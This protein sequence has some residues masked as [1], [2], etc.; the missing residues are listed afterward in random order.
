MH[1]V[2]Q[3]IHPESVRYHQRTETI[4]ILCRQLLYPLLLPQPLHKIA[5][6]QN[7]LMYK[8]VADKRTLCLPT[9]FYYV[10]KF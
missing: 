10:L 1:Q 4:Y 7:V 9:S 6:C 3:E 2:K 5:L 8:G